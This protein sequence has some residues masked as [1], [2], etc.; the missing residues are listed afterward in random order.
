MPEYEKVAQFV[1]A[2]AA[3]HR[4]A[5][6]RQTDTTTASYHRGTATMFDA[7]ASDIRAEFKS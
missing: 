7:L 1:E 6:Q 4:A 5:A 3:K 2:R